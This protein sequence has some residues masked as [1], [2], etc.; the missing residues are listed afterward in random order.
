MNLVFDVPQARFN[1][2]NQ[3]IKTWNVLDNRVLKLL[4]QLPRENFVPLEYKN[5]AFI[6]IEIPL[7]QG[8]MLSP[9]LEARVLQTMKMQKTDK[10]LEIG[11]G[12][13]YLTALIA[14]L[15]NFIYSFELNPSNKILAS[16]NLTQAKINNVMLI[17]G[18][19]LNGDS[20][21]AP[22]DKIL[23]GGAV[24]TVP[25]ILLEQI[26]IGGCIFAFVLE[27]GGIINFTRYHKITNLDHKIKKLFEANVEPLIEFNKSSKFIF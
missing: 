25:K 1:M 2:I 19:G 26:K 27:T 23:I 20:K 3:Q 10:I 6:D 13:G 18:N 11:A 5:I 15:S 14:K 8:A 12:C 24:D 9:K 22:Y 21:F 4:E 16:N 17:A 7:T